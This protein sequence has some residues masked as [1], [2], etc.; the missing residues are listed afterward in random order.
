MIVYLALSKHNVLP[1]MSRNATPAESAC[2]LS[3]VPPLKAVGSLN[4]SR[5]LPSTPR[6]PLSPRPDALLG[7]FALFE[8]QMLSRFDGASLGKFARDHFSKIAGRFRRKPLYL[9]WEHVEACM[10]QKGKAIDSQ[11]LSHALRNNQNQGRVEF[12]AAE[13]ET[14]AFRGLEGLSFKTHVKVDDD[15]YMPVSKFSPLYLKWE[16]VEAG[17]IKTGIE[18]TSSTLAKVLQN[19]THTSGWK[20]F[21]EAEFEAFDL[22]GLSYKSYI[23]VGSHLYRPVQKFRPKLKHYT[24]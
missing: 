19:N 7:R 22:R 8:R 2:A 24:F 16:K 4:S 11:A 14:L 10:I 21:T 12:T 1:D 20:L 23:Y 15:C 3:L 13:F 17:E 5:L 9:K 18:I 6:S